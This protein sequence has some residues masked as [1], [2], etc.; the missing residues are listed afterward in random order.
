MNRRLILY[1]RAYEGRRLLIVGNFSAHG[2]LCRIPAAF[3]AS[4]LRVRLSNYDPPAI[5]R[6]I[7]LRP[8]EAILFEEA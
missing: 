7:T 6:E 2:T 1:S 5:A 4:R 3:E 8:Y